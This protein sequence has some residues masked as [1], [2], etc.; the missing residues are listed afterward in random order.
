MVG[1]LE[2]AGRYDCCIESPC[3]LCAMRA[4]GCRCGPAARKG[5]PV[6]DEC[7][8]MWIQGQ[9]AEPVEAG[10]IRSFLE[11]ERMARGQYGAICG[12]APKT[13]GAPTEP[14]QAQ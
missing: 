6:C 2:A 9:G 5:E 1:E 7:A 14:P 13:L 8:V 3:K 4:G 11:A 10:T 12:G